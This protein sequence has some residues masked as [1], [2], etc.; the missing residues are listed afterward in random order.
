MWWG[1][2]AAT[3]TAL[4]AWATVIVYIGLFFYARRQVGEARRLREEQARPFVVVDFELGFLVFLTVENLGR[5][6]ARNVTIRLDKPLDSTLPEPH[7]F[8]ESPIFRG[9]PIPALPPGKQVRV[10]FDQAAARLAS[11]LP[12][13]YEVEVRYRG[14]FG[15]KY[16]P[17]TYRLDLG[18]YSGSQLPRKGLPELV[19]E[20]KTIR[21]E[22]AKWR[23]GTSGLLVHTVD[24]RRQDRRQLRRYNVRTLRTQGPKAF[25]RQLWQRALW[26]LGIR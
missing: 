25:A 13:S 24:K 4:A 2:D 10:L 18:V 16:E 19:D 15:Q 23:P 3:W 11:D 8:D 17:D 21:E 9:E 22:L 5:T 12:R 7:D 6:M 20:V 1:L 14:P 26:R